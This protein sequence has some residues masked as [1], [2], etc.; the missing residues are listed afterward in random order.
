VGH[1]AF[2]VFLLRVLLILGLAASV[3]APNGAA[4]SIASLPVV[5]GISPNSGPDN[6]PTSV[7]I[8]GSALSGATAVNFG[9]L[10]ATITSNTD[11]QIVVTPPLQSG[12]TTVDVTVTTAAGT[13]ATTPADRYTYLL[14]PWENFA[15]K[16]ASTPVAGSLGSPTVDAFVAGADGAL[17]HRFF[18]ANRIWS[19]ESLGGR[20]TSVAAPLFHD[21]EID[22]FVRGADLALWENVFHRA[23]CANPGWS[24]WR[25]LGG[26][27]AAEPAVSAYGYPT[28]STIAVFA[29][30]TDQQL[31]VDRLDV[32]TGTWSWHPAG[33]RIQAAPSAVAVSDTEAWAFVQGA[34]LGLWYWSNVS[35]WHP[36]GGRLA[37]K[38]AAT[39]MGQ[40][41]GHVDA[42]VMGADGQ[43]WHWTSA[44][45]SWEAVG[46]RI[47]GAPSAQVNGGRYLSNVVAV[48]GVDGGLWLAS[49]NPSFPATGW[50]WESWGGA[51]LGSPALVAGAS[52]AVEV[53]VQGADHALWHRADG[54]PPA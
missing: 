51:I 38:P 7:T 12:G 28:I 37:A 42:F 47:A 19:W 13:S 32:A 34:D 1:R 35:G 44:N 20:P 16:L 52:A 54:A 43:L 26:K 23:T 6:A 50:S 29:Q 31:W 5:S 11:T 14:P 40:P 45:G 3:L 4:A 2:G 24:G 18:D 27:L 46:G 33:G 39:W 48:R 9:T 15:G 22:V 36:L 17:W 30:G 49:F 10:T 41:S 21:C 8:D 53:F 25:S